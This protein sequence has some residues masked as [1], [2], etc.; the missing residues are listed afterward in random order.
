MGGGKEMD[1]GG[2]VH[3]KLNIIWFLKLPT[4]K[5]KLKNGGNLQPFVKGKDVQALQKKKKYNFKRLE[6]RSL[7]N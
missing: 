1:G 4:L 6:K 2:Y 7:K 5:K 3:I